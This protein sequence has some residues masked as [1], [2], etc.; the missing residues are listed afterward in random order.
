MNE[1]DAVQV[2]TQQMHFFTCAQLAC[3][4]MVAVVKWIPS[5]SI[6]FPFAIF[7]AVLMRHSALESMFTKQELSA[8]SGWGVCVAL[9]SLYFLVGRR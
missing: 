9:L 5:I 6:A 2:R 7:I 4:F 8:V 3:F 1:F